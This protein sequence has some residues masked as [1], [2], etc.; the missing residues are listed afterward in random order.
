MNIRELEVDDFHKGFLDVLESFGGSSDRKISFDQFK[1]HFKKVVDKK[2]LV[3]VVEDDEIIVGCGTILVEHKFH[4]GFCSCAHIEDIAVSPSFR[5]KKIG[6][7]IL[8]FL[9]TIALQNKCY[10]I[11]L[12]TAL[13]NISFYQK[14]GFDKRGCVLEMFLL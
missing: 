5:N 11:T 4:N 6:S 14:N 9:T 7:R 1:S 13:E 12:A 3:Y 10:K 2:N 8:D